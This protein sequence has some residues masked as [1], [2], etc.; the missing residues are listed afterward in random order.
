MHR[1]VWLI[2]VVLTL[3]PTGGRAETTAHAFTFTAIEG[4]PLEMAGFRGRAVLVVNT[5]SRCGFTQ[6]YDDLQ[7]LYDRYRDGG[8]VVLGVP[9]NDFGAQ[10]PGSEAQIKRFCEVNFGIDFPM[11]AKTVVTGEGAHPFYAWAHDTLGRRAAPRW[12]FH[13]YLI[14]PDG[15]LVG[16]FP[17]AMSPGAPAV[18]RAVEAALPR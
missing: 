4:G 6:Q 10:E 13:K 12:N 18:T 9:S 11:T 17:S 15:A 5:A 2:A 3:V 7:A 1:L 16:W 14:D 8:L